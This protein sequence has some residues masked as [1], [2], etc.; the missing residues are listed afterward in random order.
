M[1]EGCSGCAL[2]YH[3][4][5]GTC[6]PLLVF[7]LPFSPP[8][9]VILPPSLLLKVRMPPLLP[10]ASSSYTAFCSSSSSAFSSSSSSHACQ[11]R[12]CQHMVCVD[13]FGTRPR[14]RTLT[15]IILLIATRLNDKPKSHLKGNQVHE[16]VPTS[17]HI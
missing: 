10:L 12:I 4:T 6:L 8:Y 1:I 16:F 14:S 17:I 3:T 15:P 2:W 9:P 11:I 7:L 5:A 13:W